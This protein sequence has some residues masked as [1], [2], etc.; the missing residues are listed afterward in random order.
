MLTLLAGADIEALEIFESNLHIFKFDFD[1][2]FSKSSSNL[3]FGGI[4]ANLIFG[5]IPNLINKVSHHFYFLIQKC[6]Y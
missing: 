3:I 4:L 1:V 6:K 2:K 5:D